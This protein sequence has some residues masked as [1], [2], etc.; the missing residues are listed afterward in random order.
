MYAQIQLQQI[1]YAQQVSFAIQQ[2]V[3]RKRLDAH[4]III[5]LMAFQCHND[6][7]QPFFASKVWDEHQGL[8]TSVKQDF[9]AEFRLKLP[10]H[11]KV[12]VEMTYIY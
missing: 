5:V 6:A 11:A 9:I 8:Q 1:C 2:M 4:H 3:R 7:D 10:K 12:K